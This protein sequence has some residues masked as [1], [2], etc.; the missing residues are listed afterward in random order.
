MCTAQPSALV[1]ILMG[2]NSVGMTGNSPLALSPL[3]LL[4]S[5]ESMRSTRAAK[6]L[7]ST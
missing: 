6:R 3:E 5:T 4:S 1:G 2:I 7:F